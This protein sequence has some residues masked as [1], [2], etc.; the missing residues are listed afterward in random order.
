MLK[1]KVYFYFK[2]EEDICVFTFISKATFLH[3][4]IF[5]TLLTFKRVTNT[6]IAV[7]VQILLQT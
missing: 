6:E 5:M 1:N 7:I 4:Y 2:D 3:F